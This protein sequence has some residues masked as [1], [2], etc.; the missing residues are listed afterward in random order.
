M[1]EEESKK[2]LFRLNKDYMKLPPKERL[3]HYNE[4]IEERNKI[5]DKLKQARKK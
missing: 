3:K 2:A 1:T 5:K 4:Y